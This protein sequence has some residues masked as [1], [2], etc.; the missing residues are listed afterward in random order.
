MPRETPN[1]AVLPI[2]PTTRVILSGNPLLAVE[3]DKYNDAMRMD[4]RAVMLE[5]VEGFGGA[6]IEDLC[7][8][9]ESVHLNQRGHDLIANAV[10]RWLFAALSR[11]GT[12]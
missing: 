8:A 2:F 5:S 10:K 6:S 3:I 4:P 7:V 11:T 9:P 1:V 12:E